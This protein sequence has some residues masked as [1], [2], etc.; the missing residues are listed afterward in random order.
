[1]VSE[2][3]VSARKNVD[4]WT[5][6]VAFYE[7]QL[8]AQSRYITQAYIGL[9]LG[10]VSFGAGFFIQICFFGTV[11]ALAGLLL[12]IVNVVRRNDTFAELENSRIQLKH[13]KEGLYRLDG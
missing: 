4:D 7:K 3:K 1:M 10:I 5:E 12:L 9:L 6:K 13:W 8:E 11:F 2:E